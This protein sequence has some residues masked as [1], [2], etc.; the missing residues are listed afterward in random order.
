MWGCPFKVVCYSQDMESI[1]AYRHR[2]RQGAGR[3]CRALLELVWPT[4]CAGCERLGALLCEDCQDAL[5]RIDQSGACPRCGAP[6]G[7]LVCTECTPIYE[8]TG[9]AFRQARCAL[10][11]SALTRRIIIAYKDGGDRRLAP[12]LAR[13]LATAIPLEWRRWADAFTWIPADPRALRRRG[14]DHME[15]IARALFAQTG[16]RAVSILA[17]RERKDQRRLNRAQRKDNMSQV[18][19]VEEHPATSL[20]RPPALSRHPAVSPGQAP[21]PSCRPVQRVLLIDDV[22]TTGA[23]LDTA[24]R[25][26]LSAGIRE[27]R[28]ATI[29]RVW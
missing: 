20:G 11:F 12:V 4:R 15:L 5:P 27:V 2:L 10:E 29:A 23:T 26:L 7:R 19:F 13:I 14:F 21:T 16:L 8:Q 22:F 3:L 24:T 25:T 6:A 9:F 18:F 1:R 28:V 17:R